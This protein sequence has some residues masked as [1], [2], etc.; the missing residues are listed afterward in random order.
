MT[1]LKGKLATA[2]LIVV[3]ASGVGG[4]ATT[5]YVDQQIATVNQRIDGV[6]SRLV[7]TENTANT[8]LSQ[9]Q[10]ANTAA[11]NANRRLDA[12]EQ[13]LNAPPPPPPP[14]R[15]PRN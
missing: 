15:A 1:N 7:Q 2:A 8:A 10:A 13:R 9:A 14:P 6:E 12:V 4:C 3:S 11:T 5:E